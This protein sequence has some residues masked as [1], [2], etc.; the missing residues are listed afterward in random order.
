MADRAK[1]SIG[2]AGLFVVSGALVA[3]GP[4]FGQNATDQP[5]TAQAGDAITAPLQE[6]VVTAER[7]A[8]NIQTT[9]ISVV[10]VSGS[11]LQAASVVNINNITTVAPD[12]T[13]QSGNGSSAINIRGV[14]IEPVG[15]SEAGVAVVRDGIINASPGAGTDM[16]FYDIADVEVLRGPQGTFAGDNSTGGAIYINSQNPNFRG[17]NGYATVK[18]G[19]YS[20]TGLQGAVN[21][22]VTDTLAM[23]LAFNQEQRGSFY[24]DLGSAL[25]GPNG[26]APYYTAGSPTCTE[27][28]CASSP[29]TNKTGID[30][31]NLI[32]R[33]ARLGL[34][35]KPTDNFQSLTKIEIDNNDTDGLPTQPNINTFAPLAPGLPCPTGHGTAPNCTE[36]YLSGYSGSPYILNSWDQAEKWYE[37]ISMYS[38]ELRYTLS[39]GT[40]ARLMLGDTEMGYDTLS[41][42]TAD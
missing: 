31:G 38:E 13:I 29:V 2:L 42:T 40:V 10:A 8:E 19:T 28:Y 17:V 3:A 9:P 41:N 35:W 20:D 12:V 36:L 22:P 25:S 34:L 4:A 33:D 16:P 18:V 23:R 5:A 26:A 6:I 15:L 37:H 21:L 30:P 39:G 11:D 14:G 24:Y 7:R 27:L 1:G 32:A